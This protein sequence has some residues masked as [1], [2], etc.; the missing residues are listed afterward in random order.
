MLDQHLKI[1]EYKLK[2]NIPRIT[3]SELRYI[4]LLFFS[5]RIILT[6]IGVLSRILFEPYHGKEYVWIY[7]DKLWMDIWGVWDTGWYLGIAANG[8][9]A[10][11]I[12]ILGNQ[13]NYNFFPLYPLFMRLLG[14]VTRDNYLSGIIIS[15]VA[16][17]VSCVFLYKLVELD[18]DRDTALRSVKFLFLFPTAYILSGVFT[19]SLFLAL[20][21]ACFYYA[22]KGN[23]FLVGMLGFCLSLTRAVGVLIILPVLYEYLKSKPLGRDIFYLLLIP[24]GIFV[25]MV[26]N[27]SLTGDF[28][29]F[30]HIQSTW[31]RSLTNPLVT[32]YSALFSNNI[33]K[34]FEAIFT[35]I[36]FSILILFYNKI[37]TSYW[38]FGMFCLITPLLT[39]IDSMPRYTLVV[40]PFFIIFA[41]L[42]K[43]H[44][45]D[46]MLASFL[47]LLQGCLMVFWS[48][49]FALII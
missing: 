26:F 22:R 12:A 8:Y 36:S 4:L 21:L 33:V 10:T 43:E 2:T 27:F 16:L 13:A 40:F 45:T 5:T 20:A 32:I 31:N 6:L 28:L 14:Y 19:E 38:I 7:S 37:R 23:W 42:T 9:S 35:V 49:G 47:A 18:E 39:S 34:L 1:I 44:P 15:N 46:D 11:A 30:I 29:A 24:F 48:N 41:Q 25:W 17:L 3:L